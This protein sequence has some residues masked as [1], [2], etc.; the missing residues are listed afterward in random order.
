MATARRRIV[1][2]TTDPPPNPAKQRQLQR[3]RNRLTK[4]SVALKRWWKR[5][6]RAIN[7]V[8]K[9]E[10]LVKNL[11]RQIAQHGENANGQDHRAADLAQG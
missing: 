8:E 4:E 1:R 7:A 3:L 10:R 5:L 11:E 2:P 9:Y 6:R